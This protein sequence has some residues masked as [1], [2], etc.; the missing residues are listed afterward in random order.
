MP[1]LKQR[2][3]AL[4]CETTGIDLHHG[5]K[6]F[7]VSTCDQGGNIH[8]WEAD[9]DP[10]TRE[11]HWSR[12]DLLEIQDTIDSADK[13]ILQNPKFDFRALSMI[14]IR[15][16]W[17]WHKTFDTLMAGH[18]L[19]S[20][21]PHDLTT[22]VMVNLRVNIQPFEDRLEAA[23]KEAIK[24]VKKEHPDWLIGKEGLTCMPSAKEKTWKYDTWLP[25]TIASLEGYS[26]DHHFWTVLED[27]G[28]TDSSVTLPLYLVQERTL[29]R[30]GLWSIYQARMRL[31]PSIYRMEAAG[32]TMSRERT[33]ELS[34]RMLEETAQCREECIK[35]ADGEIEDLPVNG[36]SN[37]LRHVLFE[38]FALTSP[39]KT[40]G[41]KQSADKYVLDHWIA[42]L[43]EKSRPWKFVNSLRRYRKRKTALGY[44]ASYEKF[45]LPTRDQ[46]VMC[47]P[48][49][50]PTNCSPWRIVYPS[51]NPTGTDTLRFSSQNPNAQQVSKQEE[52]NTRYCFGPLP[53]REWW[54][55][56]FSNL[57]LRIPAYESGE[58]EMVKL[59][60]NPDEPPYF[61]SYHLLVFDTL[62]PDKF[63]EHGKKCK[64]VYAD[65]WYQWTKNGNFA[66][67]YG[68]V[69]HSGTAD[70]AYHVKGAQKR[71]MSRFTKIKAL[72]QKW[73]DFANDC[74]YV[75][76]MPDKTV[77]P[78]RGYPLY[79]T[80]TDYGRI[81]ETVPLSYHVQGTAMWITTKAMFRCDEYLRKHPKADGRMIAQVHDEILFDFPKGEG[82]KHIKKLGK[83]MEQSGDDVG[84]PLATTVH[85]HPTAWSLV[86][87]H[88]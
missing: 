20:N 61:G 10:L 19:I 34:N 50:A 6:P 52:T 56:D 68:A 3:I 63:A 2:I 23:V 74:G 86:E 48:G 1:S 21:Q 87:E 80:R 64:D 51:Y 53:G 18:L 17:P 11:P 4:D 58:E 38:K 46:T 37:A 43:P 59:F 22:M 88:V 77:D 40:K 45:W 65:T 9:V 31:L 8:F 76:T 66:V 49:E 85:Y 25:R 44:L 33:Y 47:R 62:H 29:V 82:H 26:E 5:A 70:K 39:K 13:L 36:M 83:L 24:F 42:T 57:E 14:G 15:D 54:S 69:E 28:N 32:M 60:E 30:L 71:I 27:Y 55:I 73:I 12:S 75:E 35:Q 41:G 78:L 7:F 84:V 67:Q 16:D 81:L 72:G 79:C